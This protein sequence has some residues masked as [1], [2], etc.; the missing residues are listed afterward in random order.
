MGTEVENKSVNGEIE[1]KKMAITLGI[2]Q[3]GATEAYFL[4]VDGIPTEEFAK[5]LASLVGTSVELIA[6]QLGFLQ[7]PDSKKPLIIQ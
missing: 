1:K 3:D 4:Q 6:Q 5:S 7:K 2:G